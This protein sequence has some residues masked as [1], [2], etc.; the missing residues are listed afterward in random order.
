MDRTKPPQ[1]PELPPYKLPPVFETKLPNG[2]AVLLVE[3][4]R[5]PIVTAR[6]GFQAGSKYDPKDL[7]G[8]S[9]TAGALLTEGTIH[10]T[11]RQ[12]A[13]ETAAIGG[14]LHADA[15]ADSLVLAG[16]SLSENLPV[17]LELMADVARNASFPDDE[18][19][20]RKQNRK[21]DSQPSGPMPGSSPARSL[22][23][24]SSGR[25]RTRARTRRRNR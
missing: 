4:G 22:L 3:D 25:T 6:L 11:A 23:R 9:E 19:A 12:I 21:R 10:R 13:E 7:A 24:S 16:N 15:S 17:L 14:S 1:T 2:L 8:L 20:L 18:V 5:F